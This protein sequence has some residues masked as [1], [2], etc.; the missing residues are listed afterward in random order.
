MQTLAEANDVYEVLSHEDSDNTMKTLGEV[1]ADPA[2]TDICKNI[3]EFLSGPFSKNG[4][5]RVRKAKS[6][7]SNREKIIKN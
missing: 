3:L 2:V 6:K 7:I 5:S 1:C 4:Y